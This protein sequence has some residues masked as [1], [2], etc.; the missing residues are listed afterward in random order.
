MERITLL[1]ALVGLALAIGIAWQVGASELNNI[2]LHDDLRD[3]AAHND[4]RIGSLS[5]KSDDEIRAEVVRAAAEH[6]LLLKPQQ[7]TLVRSSK[8]EAPHFDISVDYN[9][10]VNLLVYSFNIHFIQTSAK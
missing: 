6:G 2:E 1:I 7:V 3:V 4:P 9:S 10:H 5:S 8:S